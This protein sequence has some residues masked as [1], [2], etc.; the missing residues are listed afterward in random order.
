MSGE[1]KD[2]RSAPLK[3]TGLRHRWTTD[4]RATAATGGVHRAACR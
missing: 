1:A 2:G 4:A 3:H